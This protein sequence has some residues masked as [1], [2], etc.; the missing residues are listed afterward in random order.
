[1]T[2]SGWA[3]VT[4]ASGGMGAAF[5]RA[6]A[7]RGHP[8]LAVARSAESLARVADEVKK[9]GG[10]V[11]TLAVDLASTAGVAAVVARA[12]ALGD[13]ELLVNNAGLST[14]GHFLGSLSRSIP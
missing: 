4:G 14:S 2:G 3:I 7:R 5:T 12:Q 9:N 1:M 13:V 6:L 8:V 10:F 11:E